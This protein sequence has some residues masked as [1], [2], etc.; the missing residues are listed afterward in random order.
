[1]NIGF[2]AK[3]VFHN[4]TGLGNYSRDLVRILRRYYPQSRYFLYNPKA[5][6]KTLFEPLGAQVIEKRPSGI[7][8]SFFSNLWRR[9]GMVKDLKRDH[10][11]LFHGLSGELPVGL[12]KAGI[13]SVVTIHDVLFLRYPE[14]YS[15]IDRTIYYRKFKHAAEAA[16]KVIAISEQTKRD[17]IQYLGIPEHKI[18]VVYQGCHQAFKESYTAVQKTALRKKYQ[19]PEQFLLNVGTI[20]SRKNILVAVKALKNIDNTL[21]I[22]GRKTAYTNEITRFIAENKLEH[23]VIFLQGLSPQELAMLYQ[24]ADVFIYPSLFEGFGIPII[25]ALFS[26]TPVI[27]SIGSCF[28]EAGGPSTCYIDPTNVDD[29]AAAIRNILADKYLQEKM[30]AEGNSYVQKFT[31]ESIAKNLV[32]VYQEF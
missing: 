10:I 15:F 21:V 11:E 22:V 19:L 25:E 17:I 26:N 31:D 27:T 1:M 23:K 4:T 7:F 8:Y 16:D 32:K 3:R 12:K 30:I 5:S 28:P 9:F 18:T 20:E 14:F 2:E 13:K 29:V 24:L 6:K